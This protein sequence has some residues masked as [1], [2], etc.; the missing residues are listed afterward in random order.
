MTLHER[1]EEEYWSF[2]TN[3]Q[4]HFRSKLFYHLHFI[5]DLESRIVPLMSSKQSGL[6]HPVEVALDH[7]SL[8]LIDPVRL[9]TRPELAS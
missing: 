4:V 5:A 2:L 8:I 3:F 1:L 6:K 9:S 7:S